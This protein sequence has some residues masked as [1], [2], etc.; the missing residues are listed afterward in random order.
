MVSKFP[1]NTL[2]I[3]G[4]FLMK[5][6]FNGAKHTFNGDR[7][8][9]G[10]YQFIIKTRSLIR[11][12]NI[13]KVIVFWD[14]E[15][16]G[17]LRYDIYNDYKANRENKEWYKKIDLTPYEL[18]KQEKDK[19]SYLWQTIRVKNYLEELFIR[20]IE[21]DKI[22]SDDM[23]SYYCQKY[24]DKENI[25]IYTNDRDICQLL[26]YDNVSVY[27][28]NLKQN[29]TKKNYYLLFK[30]HYSN[31][32][33]IKTMCGDNSDNIC[34]IDGLAENTLIKYFPK[35]KTEKV[36]AATI[37]KEAKQINEERKI[38]K[39]KPLKVLDNIHEGVFKK[40]GKVGLEQYKLNYK[41]INLLEPFLTKEAMAELCLISEQPLD[42]NGRGEQ[43][44]LKLLTEDGF[45]QIYNSDFINFHQPF[46]PVI[47]REKDF[48]KKNMHI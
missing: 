24:H 8:I 37:I 48:Y 23:F 45:L 44:L 40:Y 42:P 38:N 12:L 18:R 25:I 17:K 30:H 46:Y 6:S 20:Q 27:L 9:G 39:K 3:D 10:L 32:T 26:E 15:N 11:T 21:V 4:N 34:G 7:H 5:R 13:N 43:N 14:G 1:I 31:L 19:E 35:I 47:I 29:V 28:D 36:K 2:L 16:S 22:E 41:I 33:V